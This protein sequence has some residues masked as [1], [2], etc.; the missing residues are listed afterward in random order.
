ME[1][2][3]KRQSWLIELLTDVGIQPS[4]IIKIKSDLDLVYFE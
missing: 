3:V 4:R 2:P 1:V